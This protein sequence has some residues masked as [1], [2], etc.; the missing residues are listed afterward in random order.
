MHGVV[1]RICG[2]G[3]FRALAARIR[4]LAPGPDGC[5]GAVCADELWGSY[6][7]ALAAALARTLNRPLLY[8]TAHLEQADEARDDLE[9]FHGSTPELLS[10]FETLPGEGAG[11]DEIHAERISLCAR[12]RELALRASADRSACRFADLSGDDPLLL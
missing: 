2:D 3:T 1:E 6:A 10:A 9:L 5:T 11:S 12:L 8:V 7:P 4:S